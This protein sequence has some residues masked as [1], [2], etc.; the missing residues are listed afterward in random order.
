MP[1]DSVSEE[2]VN[3]LNREHRDKSDE[4]ARIKETSIQQ[5]WLSEL[6]E[7][8]H[9]YIKYR[10]DRSQIAAPLKKAG[11]K[12]VVKQGSTTNKKVVKKAAVNLVEDA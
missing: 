5:M 7:L 3:K 2:N 11:S 10:D 9:E 1:M 8:E 4:L 6:Q 12:I